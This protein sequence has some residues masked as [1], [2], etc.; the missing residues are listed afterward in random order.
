VELG[1]RF[2]EFEGVSCGCFDGAGGAAGDYGY[3]GGS[4]GLVVGRRDGEC[5][6]CGGIGI[7][8]RIG[9]KC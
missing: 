4:R 3:Y 2:G 1:A 9:R 8:T 5:R 7:R 6:N